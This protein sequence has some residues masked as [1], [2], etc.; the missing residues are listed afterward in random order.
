MLSQ[1]LAH[2]FPDAALEAENEA[3]P[4]A[5]QEGGRA[6]F[7]LGDPAERSGVVLQCFRSRYRL[8]PEE[9][10]PFTAEARRCH[11]KRTRRRLQAMGIKLTELPRCCWDS[12]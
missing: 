8:A 5:W 6:N 4:V 11:I 7:R 1:C 3:G 12:T 2:F 10:A 9:P